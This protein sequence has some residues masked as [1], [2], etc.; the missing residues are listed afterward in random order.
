M[1]KQEEN[2][3]PKNILYLAYALAFSAI[4]PMLDTTMVNIAINKLGSDFNT[5]LDTIQWAITGYVLALAIAV[6]ISGWLINRFNG[7]II[8]MVA[9]LSFMIASILSGI[10]WNI[11]SF[12]VFRLIQG[13]TSGIIVPIMMTLLM[14]SANKNMIGR[15]A[16]TVGTPTILGPILGPVIGGLIVQYLS[17]RWIFFVNIPFVLI[18][19]WM[20]K[21]F[22]PNFEPMNSNAKID[23]LGIII[24]S[25]M[26]ASII[27]GIVKAS[28]YASFNNIN[29]YIF[30]GIGIFLLI[31]YVIYNHYKDNKVI[32]PLTLFKHRNFSGAT[33][34]MFL[35]G[36]ATNGPMLLLPLYF[37]NIK[38]FSVV[39]AALIL[40]PQGIG[41]FIARP[42]IGRIMDQIGSKKVVMVSLIIS[43]IGSIPFIFFDATSNLIFI[44]IVLFIRGIGVGGIFLPLMGDAYVGLD[45][46]LINEASIATRI[47]QNIGSSF[48][49]ATLATIVS[50]IATSEFKITSNQVTSLLDGYHIGFLVSVLVIVVM[51]IP[52]LFLSNKT[53]STT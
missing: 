14:K 22:L 28:T 21:K 40:I 20:L 47:I 19:L 38:N 3:I 43:L 13:A 26:S 17:W 35:A 24:L 1:K 15:L 52:A 12:I 46:T 25:L 6:P 2:A 5:S 4:A 29:T 34:G 51:F 53:K 45:K 42:F 30:V 16:A 39:Q 8:M 37:Q 23:W 11:T 33:I 10:A 31:I 36:I 32:V 49:T 27:Y 18:S 50:A 48:G 41:M 7:K 44:S 9:S